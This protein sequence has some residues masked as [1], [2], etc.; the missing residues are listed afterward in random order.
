M[1]TAIAHTSRQSGPRPMVLQRWEG[2]AS[3]RALADETAREH[4]S[5]GDRFPFLPM[6]T[7]EREHV[8]TEEAQTGP[9]PGSFE[10]QSN[11]RLRISW[12]GGVSWRPFRGNRRNNYPS[13]GDHLE[14]LRV[15]VTSS[16]PSIRIFVRGTYGGS[17]GAVSAVHL[18]CFMSYSAI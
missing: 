8:R 15:V 1:P 4:E 16:F 13:K 14:R 7:A 11:P 17:S 12:V 5:S 18:G 2:H 9:H 10:D 3:M 6:G